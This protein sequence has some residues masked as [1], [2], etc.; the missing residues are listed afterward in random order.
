[1]NKNDTGETVENE[2]CLKVSDWVTFLTS[3]KQGTIN[4]MVSFGML[5]VA[6]I[7]MLFSTRT[8]TTM[9][10]IGYG[11]LAFALLTYV[12]IVVFAPFQKQTRVAEKILKKIMSGDLKSES[13]I[14]E[15]WKREQDVLRLAQR[16]QR[17][18]EHH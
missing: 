14:R 17:S 10:G 3:E 16:R 9:Q 12:W 13:S 11:I 5:L 4:T 2:S 15:E 8:N 7:S 18:A 1:M 6:L